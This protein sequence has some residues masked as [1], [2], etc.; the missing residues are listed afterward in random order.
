MRESVVTK[1]VSNLVRKKFREVGLRAG[2]CAKLIS[3]AYTSE[4]ELAYKSSNSYLMPVYKMQDIGQSK[5]AVVTRYAPMERVF[6]VSMST[7]YQTPIMKKPHRWM[8]DIL[9]VGI[10]GPVL[11][12]QH[13]E[14]LPPRAATSIPVDNWCLKTIDLTDPESLGRISADID[15]IFRGWLHPQPEDPRAVLS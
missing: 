6:F 3:T 15:S 10:E 8:R 12:M 14:A 13:L 5:R 7:T 4:A 1:V 2:K 11:I 9:I